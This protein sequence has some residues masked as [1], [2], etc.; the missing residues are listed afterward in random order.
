MRIYKDLLL[1]DIG[2]APAMKSVVD[3]MRPDIER[4]SNKSYGMTYAGVLPKHGEQISRC[5]GGQWETMGELCDQLDRLGSI[6][7]TSQQAESTTASQSDAEVDPEEAMATFHVFIASENQS[8]QNT[9]GQANGLLQSNKDC[10]RPRKCFERYKSAGNT[11][12]CLVKNN[13][14]L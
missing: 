13:K 1:E 7:T 4:M 8:I 12:G 2:H 10:Q 14:F 11:T 6:Q 9:P 5:L 3:S